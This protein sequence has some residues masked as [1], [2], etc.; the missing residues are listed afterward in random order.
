MRKEH[1]TDYV[2][3]ALRYY[4][5]TTQKNS[6]ER[7]CFRTEADHRNWVAVEAALND[8]TSFERRMFYTLYSSKEAL[9]YAVNQYAMRYSMD[10]DRIWRMITEIER[11]VAKRRGLI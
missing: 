2:K 6:V 7:P 8:Y 11:N 4:I 9:P 10:I 1:Y 3:H 5:R